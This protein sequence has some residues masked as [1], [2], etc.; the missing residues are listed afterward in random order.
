MSTN[1]IDHQQ[2]RNAVANPQTPD[3]AQTLYRALRDGWDLPE[4]PIGDGRSGIPITRF[5]RKL[6]ESH[7]ANADDPDSETLAERFNELKSE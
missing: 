2:V 7:E 6:Y 3:N 5:A 4:V 1:D